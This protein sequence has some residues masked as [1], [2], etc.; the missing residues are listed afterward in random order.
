MLD[1]LGAVRVRDID[2]TQAA[3]EPCHQDDVAVYGLLRLVRAEPAIA[4]ERLVMRHPPRRD[5][6]R[7]LFVG[8]IDDPHERVR[9]GRQPV[10]DFLVGN[11]RDLASHQFVRDRQDRVRRARIGRA[12]VEAADIGR[13]AQVADV[14]D[15]KPAVPVARIEPVAA[16]QRVV[17]A[18]P[19]PRPS[20]L[21]AAFGPLTLHPPARD[22]LGPCRVGEVEDHD[23]VAD[24]PVF[25]G[26]DIR[27]APV[28]IETVRPQ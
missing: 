9:R 18:M 11:D 2:R 27:I 3:A 17:T 15:H 20:R 22:R 28:R 4:V 7:V 8:D 26:R 10:G 14:E 21:L 19:P 16:A 25:L 13:V 24:K 1:L 6:H 12:P 5:R 23:D